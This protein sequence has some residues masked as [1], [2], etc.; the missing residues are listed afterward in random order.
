M[1]NEEQTFQD[2]LEGLEGEI[3]IKADNIACVIKEMF[4]NAESIKHEEKKLA[5]RRKAIENNGERLK[6]YLFNCLEAMNMKKIETPR[7]VI[8]IRKNPAKLIIADDFIEKNYEYVEAIEQF[9]VDKGR[10]KEDLKAGKVVEG[11]RLEQLAT[12]NIK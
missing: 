7:N 10:L 11:A 1:G 5:E 12:L 8:S 6:K 3:E 2:T 4:A 9:F